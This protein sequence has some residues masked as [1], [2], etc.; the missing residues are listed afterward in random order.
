MKNWEDLEDA[1]RMKS[2][3]IKLESKSDCIQI[4]ILHMSRYFAHNF[5]LKYRI[6]VI[7]EALES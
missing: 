3:F 2:E 7:I 1:E 6:E 4:W 5:M